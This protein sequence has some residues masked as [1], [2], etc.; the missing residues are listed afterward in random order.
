MSNSEISMCI[1]D[2]N[3]VVVGYE[4]GSEIQI[5]IRIHAEH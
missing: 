2:S 4:F 3:P 5:R 1:K